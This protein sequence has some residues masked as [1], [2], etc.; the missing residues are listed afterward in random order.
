MPFVTTQFVINPVDEIEEQDA[1]S[2][3]D[4]D[5]AQADESG[6]DDH[7]HVRVARPKEGFAGKP[8]KALLDDGR[9]CGTIISR[10]NLHSEQICNVCSRRF[11]RRNQ[12]PRFF[13]KSY[14]L[15]LR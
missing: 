3:E 6:S 10:Y 9:M 13:K 14:E 11:A 4:E 15:K 1:D 8:C 12:K 5:C 7:A 2:D